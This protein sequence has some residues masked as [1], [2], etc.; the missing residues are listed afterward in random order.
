MPINVAA[1]CRVSTDADEQISSLINQKKYFRNYIKNQKDWN[2]FDVYYDE[3]VSGTSVERRLGFQRMMDDVYAGKIQLIITKEVSRFARN[4]VDALSYTRKLKELGIGVIFVQDNIN[5]LEPDG[6]LRLTIMS[7]IAQEESRKTTTRVK[8]GQKRCM[9]Q[10]V[11][12]GRSMLGYDVRGGKMF[13]NP[14]GADIVRLIFHKYVNEKKGT[15]VIARELMEAGIRPYYVKEWS[16]TVILRVIRN[17]KYVGDLCQKK[18]YTPDYLTHKKKYNR[19]K[20][21]MIYLTDHHEPII[22]RNM[23]DKAQEILAERALSDAQKSRHSCRYWCSGKIVCGECGERFVSRTKKL[24]DGSVYKAWRCAASA[25]HGAKKRDVH[26]VEVGCINQSVNEQVLLEAVRYVLRMLKINRKS[27]IAEM[28]AEIKAAVHKAPCVDVK[29]LERE[30]RRIEEKKICLLDRMLDGT[31]S[32]GD[33]ERQ[34]KIYDKQIVENQS[35]IDTQAQT[36]SDRQACKIDEC[37]ECVNKMLDFEESD[38]NICGEVTEC[39][40]VYHGHTLGIKLRYV[41]VVML[42]YRTAGRG[43]RYTAEIEMI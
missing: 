17:E 1:Y 29:A 39:I 2:L 20:S 30:I 10:G 13:I 40:A 15:H 37:I 28:K 18:T 25:K 5:T 16:N 9:E 3:G 42:R 22:S 7:S 4:T 27:L 14:E 38:E 35:R 6:E 21:T 12:F 19:D 43:S 24:S 11:V 33:Y 23:W 36:K 32:S 8:W 31:V 26:G 34:S 41:P